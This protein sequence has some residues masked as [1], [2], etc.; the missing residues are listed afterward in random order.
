MKTTSRALLVAIFFLALGACTDSP[1]SGAIQVTST[2]DECQIAADTATSGEIVFEVTNRGEE[3]TEFYLY[4]SDGLQVIGEVED[5]GPG[6][7]R[8][9]VVE[10]V[11]GDYLTACKP[12]MTGEG[13]RAPFTVTE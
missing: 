6:L 11:P 8:N 13:I 9:L 10:A 4:A 1:D 7:T 5:I 12:G 3:A 2:A